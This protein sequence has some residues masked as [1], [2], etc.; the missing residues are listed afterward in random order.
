MTYGLMAISPYIRASGYVGNRSANCEVLGCEK[1]ASKKLF[2]AL[3]AWVNQLNRPMDL[4]P[5]VH[6]SAGGFAGMERAGEVEIS[7]SWER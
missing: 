4:L 5:F 6:M 1:A 3:N 2:A 7:V